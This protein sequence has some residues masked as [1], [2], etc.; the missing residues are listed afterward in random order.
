MHGVP[1]ALP[2]I[3]APAPGDG[4][5]G[6]VEAPAGVADPLRAELER[7]AASAALHDERVAAGGL[8]ELGIE[9]IARG[10]RRGQPGGEVRRGRGQG[11]HGCAPYRRRM[12]L[13]TGE[14]IG[15]EAT[16]EIC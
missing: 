16:S 2:A 14:T 6:E 1:D 7:R 3:D 4:V 12:R 5:P 13:L 11:G 8:P 10:T 15:P 9:A